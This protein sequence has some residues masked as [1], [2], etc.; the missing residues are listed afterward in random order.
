MLD[1]C[2]RC[3]VK[4]KQGYLC[5]IC[6]TFFRNLRVD[7]T[8]GPGAPSAARKEINSNSAGT[9]RPGSRAGLGAH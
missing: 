9:A 5:N 8:R 2:G 7:G 6:R 1:K 4:I 3:N